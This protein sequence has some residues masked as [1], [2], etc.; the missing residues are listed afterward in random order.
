MPAPAVVAP[1]RKPNSLYYFVSHCMQKSA[2]FC[3]AAQ[4]SHYY[5]ISADLKLCILQDTIEV[6]G[7]SPSS[8]S[9]HGLFDR[10]S[11]D[12]F[13]PPCGTCLEVA[14]RREGARR[15]SDSRS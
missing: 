4:S 1:R 8:E 9:T 14:R 5:C 3:S 15:C 2:V 13:S 12:H 7:H 10:S 6:D 11:S